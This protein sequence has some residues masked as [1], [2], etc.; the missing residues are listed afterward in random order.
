MGHEGKGSLHSYLKEK[1]WITE[2]SAG[3]QGLARGFAGFRVTCYLTKEGFGV[4]S[5]SSS[6]YVLSLSR[7]N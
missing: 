4:Y 6:S 7:M 2:L 1:G 5:L 3:P